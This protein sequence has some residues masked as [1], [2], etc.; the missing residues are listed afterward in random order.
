MILNKRG[1]VG[2]NWIHV[3]QENQ[4]LLDQEWRPNKNENTRW[5]TV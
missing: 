2:V 1:Y 3:V 5:L 4:K